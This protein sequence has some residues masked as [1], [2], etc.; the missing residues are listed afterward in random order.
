MFYVLEILTDRWHLLLRRENS[1]GKKPGLHNSE[2]RW[3]DVKKITQ[4]VAQ[5]GFVKINP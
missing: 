2:P 1:H 3:P 5:T 4:S